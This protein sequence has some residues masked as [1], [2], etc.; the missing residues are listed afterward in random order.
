MQLGLRRTTE[1]SRLS[2]SR[3]IQGHP[4]RKLPC[5]YRK[6]QLK[7]LAIM[8]QVAYVVIQVPPP[9]PLEGFVIQVTPG[10]T[11][12]HSPWSRKKGALQRL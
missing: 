1:G 7:E 4:L 11:V 2:Q 3:A 12:F 5:L 10:S 8:T 9:S 6:V